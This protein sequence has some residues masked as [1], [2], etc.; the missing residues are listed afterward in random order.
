MK[1]ELKGKLIP[2]ILVPNFAAMLIL[3]KES[4]S[5]EKM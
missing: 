2:I 1:F 4:D 3:M 5:V